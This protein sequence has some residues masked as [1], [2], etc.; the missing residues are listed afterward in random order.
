VVFHLAFLVSAVAMRDATGR[1]PKPKVFALEGLKICDKERPKDGQKPVGRCKRYV[2]SQGNVANYEVLTDLSWV[3]LRV[4]QDVEERLT[5]IEAD[6][7]C[8]LVSVCIQRSEFDDA[9]EHLNRLIAHTRTHSLFDAYAARITLYHAHL[10]HALCQ[11]SRAFACYRLAAALASAEEQQEQTS[12][13]LISTTTN[14]Q[15]HSGIAVARFVRVAAQA[16]ELGLRIGIAR[17]KGAE[18]DKDTRRWGDEVVKECRMLGGTLEA[19]G[20]VLE[21]CL[22]DEIVAAKYVL[23][24]PFDSRGVM[25]II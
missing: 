3:G 20:R 9:E 17:E 10:S 21:A 15:V 18:V 2:L 22:T 13:S 24:L 8:E 12:T 23:S 11:R 5:K 6:L 19:V 25:L 7:L 14:D 16:G 4:R 1:K